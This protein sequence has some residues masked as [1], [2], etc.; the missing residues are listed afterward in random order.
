MKLKNWNLKRLAML[1]G[2]ILTLPGDLLAAKGSK[3]METAPD[4]TKGG[5]RDESHDWTLGPTGARGWIFTV[6]GHS[7]DARQILITAVAGKSPADGV[8]EKGDVTPCR[9]GRQEMLENLINE[10]I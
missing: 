4:F 2:L 9:S 1:C 7:H 3:P 8:L 5:Q 6:R 10:F